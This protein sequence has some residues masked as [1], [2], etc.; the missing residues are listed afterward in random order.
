MYKK[1]TQEQ[2]SRVITEKMN[3]DDDGIKTAGAFQNPKIMKYNKLCHYN[4]CNFRYC[5]FL[6]FIF[7]LM[8]FIES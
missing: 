7:L 4:S 6:V 8:S 1:A 5:D 2:C 3:G